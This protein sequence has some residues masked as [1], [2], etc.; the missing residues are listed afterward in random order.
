MRMWCCLERASIFP[1]HLHFAC[2]RAGWFYRGA[3]GSVNVSSCWMLPWLAELKGLA[4]LQVTDVPT[5]RVGRVAA[6]IG[7]LVTGSIS[8]EWLD[9]HERMGVER[10]YR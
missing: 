3:F 1:P 4:W 6:C 2:G 5:K 8:P 9:H 7:P 10:F